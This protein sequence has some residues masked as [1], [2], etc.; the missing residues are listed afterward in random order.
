[1]TVPE[2]VIVTLRHG[3]FILRYV[4]IYNGTESTCPAQKLGTVMCTAVLFII[5]KMC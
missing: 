5:A 1:L 3:N 4:T 2:K